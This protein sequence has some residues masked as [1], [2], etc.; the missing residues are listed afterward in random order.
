MKIYNQQGRI[1]Y[2]GQV[3]DNS[4]ASDAIMDDNSLTLYIKTTEPLELPV[5]AYCTFE[6][7]KYTLMRPE[8]FKKNNSRNF[9]YTVTMESEA[10]KA[11]IWKFRNPVDGRLQ[12]SLTA[13]P[14]EHLQMV[15][16]N[17]NRRDG[18]W[19]V[20]QCIDDV[21][22]TI[23]YDHNYIIDALVAQATEFNTE[24]E[25]KGKVVNLRKVEYNKNNPLPLSYGRGNGF[26]TGV[27]RSN[28]NEN[29]P[30]EILFVQGGTKN[31]D[32]SQYGHKELLLPEG[33]E[34]AYDGQYFE[35]EEGFNEKTARHYIVS[36]D[37]L[38]IRRDDG[39]LSTLAEDSLDCSGVYP[40]REGLVSEVITVDAEKNF[41]DF[42]DSSIPSTPNF[43]DHLIEGEKMTVIF[44]S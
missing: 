17:L 24:Y 3:E 25:F 35:D 22:H 7:Q 23:T 4:Y 5:G 28:Q 29:M 20:G 33:G 18:G 21:E 39:V 26:K 10:A 12:F 36:E 27:G 38:S 13:K 19:S 30:V 34:I 44:Q 40:K 8:S 9:S 2:E 43:E 32:P 6:N 1:L 31:I 11:K 16:D 42:T 15:V 14:I 37:R 41:Y